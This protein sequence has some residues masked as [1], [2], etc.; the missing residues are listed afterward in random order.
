MLASFA[1]FERATI[2]ERSRDG[3]HRAFKNGKHI[4][5]IP[6]GYDI[7]EDDRF[8]VVEEEARIVRRIIANIA[9]G[10]T[11]YKEAKR[12]ND[13]SEP[14]PRTKYRGIARRHGVNWCHSTIRNLV[15]QRAYAGTHVVN[16]SRGIVERSVP[17]IVDPDLHRRA[18]R[19]W[20]RTSATGAAE[21]AATTS[22]AASY[23]APTAARPTSAIARL[24]DGLP[25]PLLRL[26]EEE[27]D[28]RRRGQEPHLP[29]GQG[30]VA[31]GSRLGRRTKLP[32]EPRRGPQR[33][34]E[35]LAEDREGEA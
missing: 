7:G 9:G 2:T 17:A 13:E 23:C 4:G 19:G 35:Q 32:R 34:R 8:V 26:P 10:S 29:E 24:L 25:L 20:R 21:R 16:S 3:L 30:R 1:E 33:V 31:R 28:V 12:L 14:S 11:L 22:C 18:V 27:G 15:F 5:R 6:Y